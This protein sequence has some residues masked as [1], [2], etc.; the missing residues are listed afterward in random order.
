M[1][2]IEKIESAKSI[3]E[4]QSITMQIRVGKD[5]RGYNTPHHDEVAV[6]LVGNDGAPPMECDIIVYPRDQPLLH[7]LYM[8]ANC[9]PMIY[10]IL[11]PRG[12]PGWYCGLTHVSKYS[13][14]K[15]NQVAVLCI[16]T[17]HL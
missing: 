6:V 17:G 11:F 9:D 7:V 3:A 12:D 2:E 10:P 1:A 5:R 16:S 15:R 8:S 4:C 14:E 13:T